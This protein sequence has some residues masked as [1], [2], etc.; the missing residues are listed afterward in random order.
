M[1]WNL[2]PFFFVLRRSPCTDCI[3]VPKFIFTF[4]CSAWYS[5]VTIH[6][7]CAYSWGG[8]SPRSPPCWGCCNLFQ[9]QLF[10]SAAVGRE[11]QTFGWDL[12]PVDK[13]APGGRL[14]VPV[15]PSHCLSALRAPEE[16][17]QDF[18]IIW[19]D[20]LKCCQE[21]TAKKNKSFLLES[22]LIDID[23]LLFRFLLWQRQCILLPLNIYHLLRPVDW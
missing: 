1:N 2:F 23:I 14:A 18:A 13:F 17:M 3:K 15:A 16:G 4:H 8:H 19:E 5:L 22:D 12:H 21:S 6:W 11:P 10:C 7:L 9:F 20:W